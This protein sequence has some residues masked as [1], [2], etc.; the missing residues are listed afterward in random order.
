M[1]RRS[2][3]REKRNRERERERERVRERE[4]E[5]QTDRTGMLHAHWRIRHE[6]DVHV[7]M[8]GVEIREVGGCQDEQW[9]MAW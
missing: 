7:C 4:R 8:Y 9:S 2:E 1:C 6:H 5:R 3:T